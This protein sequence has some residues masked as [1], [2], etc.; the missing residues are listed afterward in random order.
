MGST[1]SCTHALKSFRV[2]FHINNGIIQSKACS[3]KTVF[4]VSGE[5]HVPLEV[6]G[7]VVKR[8]LDYWQITEDH[9]KSCCWRNYRI[10]IEN[11]RILE[12][13]NHS[14][15]INQFKPIDYST[16]AGWE[17][18]RTKMWLIL[19]YPRTS[20]AAFVSIFVPSFKNSLTILISSKF[21]NRFIFKNSTYVHSRYVKTNV[22]CK[23]ITVL[24]HMDQCKHYDNL[25]HKIDM[26]LV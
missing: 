7:A 14:V 25:Y 13:F 15:L 20:R 21:G 24:Q 10:Y 3:Y 1:L 18:Y 6:C 8:E 23:K 26:C 4:V 2:E 12:A 16:L 17:K 5:L 9:I 22:Q 19:E 11:Q